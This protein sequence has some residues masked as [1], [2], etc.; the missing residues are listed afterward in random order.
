MLHPFLSILKQPKPPFF[1]VSPISVTA[2]ASTAALEA[3]QENLILFFC[4]FVFVSATNHISCWSEAHYF[5]LIRNCLMDEKTELSLKWC[6][7]PP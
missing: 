4:L 1:V 3:F 7:L 5:T 6:I 2:C